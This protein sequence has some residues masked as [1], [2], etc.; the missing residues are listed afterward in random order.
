MLQAFCLS[1]CKPF[2]VMGVTVF[3]DV[4]PSG[5]I[6][7]SVSEEHSAS[8]FREESGP[9]YLKDGGSMFL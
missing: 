9:F 4:M 8:I 3:Y 6:I 7:T 5:L 1:L 2:V